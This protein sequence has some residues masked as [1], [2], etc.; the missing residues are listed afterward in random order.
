[1]TRALMFVVLGPGVLTIAKAAGANLA[2]VVAYLLGG[3][4]AWT[5][6]NTAVP[7]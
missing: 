7:R 3:V 4:V 2:P 1:M 6:I 5:V